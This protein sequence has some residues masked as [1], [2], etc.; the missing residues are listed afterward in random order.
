MHSI[1]L[2]LFLFQAAPP[3]QL[4]TTEQIALSTV[5]QNFQKAIGEISEDVKKNHPGYQ[6]NTNTLRLEPIPVNPPAQAQQ[7][8]KAPAKK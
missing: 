6:L 1:L 5:V 8:A 7:P 4:S 2:A 3:Q